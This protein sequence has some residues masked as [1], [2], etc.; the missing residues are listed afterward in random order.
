MAQVVI[1][2]DIAKDTFHAARLSEGRYRHKQFVNRPEG[3]A[4]FLA[5]LQGFG[6]AAPWVCMEATGT[7]SIPLAEF[8]VAQGYRVSVVNPAK[9]HA[10]A[11]SEL[12]RAKTDKADAKLIAR[13]GLAMQPAP[14]TPPPQATRELQALLRRVEHLLEMQQMEKNRLDTADPLIVAS[15]KTV[16]DTLGKELDTVRGRIKSHIDSDPDLRQ[17]RD[18]L[19]S[20]PGVG[21][22]TA[23]WLLT[24]LS[25]HYAFANAKQAVAFA[26]LAPKLQE[27]GK[28]KGTTRLA[29]T[30]DP[31]LRKALYMPSLSAWRYSP[32]IRVFCERLKAN[33]KNGKAVACAAMRKLIH[34]AFAI[35]KSGQPFD[36]NL[37]LA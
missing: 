22:A 1:G 13:Y 27:S 15:L 11:K 10:F 17:Q 20:I 26:G 7:F 19:E 3:F 24:R 29:K 8:L 30:G 25:P 28:W 18:L 9:I 31:A 16:L 35:L 32:A 37:K 23:A 14:W 5:W 36:P 2:V 4:A 33:G 6:D 12:S 21:P 34:I